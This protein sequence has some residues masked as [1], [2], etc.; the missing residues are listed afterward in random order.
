MFTCIVFLFVAFVYNLNVK[1]CKSKIT[2]PSS[3]RHSRLMFVSWGRKNVSKCLLGW[4]MWAR[5]K[6]KGEPYKYL[7][8]KIGGCFI[9]NEKFRYFFV[10]AGYIDTITTMT[11]IKFI[12]FN[13]GISKTIKLKTWIIN[14][15]MYIVGTHIC[16]WV[17]SYV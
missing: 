9:Q 2:E 16:V 1:Q 5:G 11:T 3:H 6:Y 4:H 17:Y 15:C 13:K 10:K 14:V 12:R 7:F 8:N